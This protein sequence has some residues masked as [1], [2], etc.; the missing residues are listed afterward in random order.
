MITDGSQIQLDQTGL[1]IGEKHPGTL[2]M[3]YEQNFII[4]QFSLAYKQ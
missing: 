2:T 4:A 3:K 1:K